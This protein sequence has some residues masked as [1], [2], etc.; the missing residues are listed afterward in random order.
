MSNNGRLNTTEKSE[1][2][3]NGVSK[4]LPK[5]NNKC[6]TEV[7]SN[8]C[9]N[10]I[11]N[12]SY[13]LYR[14]TVR[15]PRKN[16]V[17]FVLTPTCFVEGSCFIYVICIYLRIVVFATMSIAHGVLTCRVTVAWRVSLVEQELVTLPEYLNSPLVF[18]GVPGARS[19]FFCVGFCRSFFVRYV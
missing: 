12:V 1:Y 10:G 17:R 14:K 2:F 8:I 6:I 16:D 19:L 5:D 4:D 13:L 7:V 3:S 11:R 15:F 18:I 9:H